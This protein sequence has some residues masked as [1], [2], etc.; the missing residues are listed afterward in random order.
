MKPIPG[1]QIEDQPEAALLPMVLWGEARGEPVLGKLAI[2]WVI[3]NRAIR[4]GTTMKD[5]ILR[6][7][8]FSSFNHDDPNR[9]KLLDAPALDHPSW[10]IC[11][12]VATLFPAT[13]DPTIGATH[14][15]AP[16]V[17]SPPWGRG[18][19]AWHETAV[20]G[21]HCFGIAA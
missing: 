13:N 1:I 5:Q 10:V 11:E 19:P 18:H 6:P 9:A 21:N 14:Y 15:Y 8:Q 3:K 2:L 17:V 16:A 4:H 7:K 20:I 12:A